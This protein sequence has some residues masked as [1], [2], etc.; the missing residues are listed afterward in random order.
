MEHNKTFMSWF[1]EQIIKD[2]SASETLTW[3][4]NGL[5]FEVFCCSSYE[6][7][8]TLFYTKSQDD[9]SIVQNSRVTLEEDSLQFST[10]KDQNPIVGSMSYYDVI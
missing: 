3:L 10:S 2:S 5:K 4:A 7:N 9:K 8:G 6:I 1:R